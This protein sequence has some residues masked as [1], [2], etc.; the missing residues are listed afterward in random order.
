MLIIPP[1]LKNWIAKHYQGGFRKVVVTGWAVDD[2][3]K[4]RYRAD[5][6]IPLSDHADFKDLINYVK[7]VSPQKVYITHGFE[8]FV[9]YLKKEGFNA[10]PLEPAAQISLF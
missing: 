5:E 6:A 1:H 2:N 9:H 3:A 10:Y 8:Q 7:Q 4:Y